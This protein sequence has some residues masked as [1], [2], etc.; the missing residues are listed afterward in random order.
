[1]LMKQKTQWG[2]PHALRRVA[3]LLL[4]S[5]AGAPAKSS[6]TLHAMGNLTVGSCDI[7]I[8]GRTDK[9]QM[10]AVQASEFDTTQAAAIMPFQMIVEN[11]NGTRAGG[12]FDVTVTG[13]TLTSAG[14]VFNDDVASDVGFML[15]EN[16][17]A[18]PNYWAGTKEDYYNAPGTVV[19]N[20]PT[21][22]TTL[23]ED[24]PLSTRLNYFL[25]FVTPLTG[26]GVDPS[27]RKVTATLTFNV[28]Y[29]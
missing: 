21:Q 19:P 4:L 9:L 16:G 1:M 12:T 18:T 6:V 2:K 13:Q 14:N 28:N 27:P 17:S 23:S 7:V 10:R 3:L 8:D 11:C 26:G 15:K 29:H 22:Q 25:G 5:T 20:L 24:N